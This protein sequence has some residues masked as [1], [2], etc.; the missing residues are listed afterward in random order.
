[1]STSG[2]QKRPSAG[3]GVAH[4][5]LRYW[6][7]ARAAAGAE[8]DVIDVDGPVSVAELRERALALHPDAETLPRVLAT[9]SVLVDDRPLGLADAASVLVPVGST[10][11]FLPPFAGG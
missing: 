5:T 8:S 9:C 4:I 7:G 11:E 3:R 6:A 10:L 1:M 2:V